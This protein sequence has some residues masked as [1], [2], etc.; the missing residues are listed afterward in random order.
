MKIIC[1]ALLVL[2]I[3]CN[4]RTAIEGDDNDNNK[5]VVGNNNVITFNGKD[6]N[7]PINKDLGVNISTNNELT[8]F[9]R[10]SLSEDGMLPENLELYSRI[11]YKTVQK[12]G[13]VIINPDIEFLELFEKGGPVTNAFNDLDLNG[14]TWAI[15]PQRS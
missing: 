13:A 8:K 2:I 12:N 1:L 3:S 7:R 9:V 15:I 5:V 4:S 10:Q 6:Y 14:G 11:K